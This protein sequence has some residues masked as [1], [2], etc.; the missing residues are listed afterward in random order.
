[1]NAAVAVAAPC[2]ANRRIPAPSVMPGRVD[3][4]LVALCAKLQAS[5]VEARKL[6]VNPATTEADRIAIQDGILEAVAET[7]ARTRAGRHA[8]AA[9]AVDAL[10]PDNMDWLHGKLVM[11]FLEGL[12]RDMLA[13]AA[14]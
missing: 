7:P 9:L 11:D 5:F 13:E 10:R 3:A 6:D 12:A 1:M 8:K 2:A 4:V 14:P